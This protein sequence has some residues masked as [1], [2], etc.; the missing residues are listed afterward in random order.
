[1]GMKIFQNQVLKQLI[2]IVD[3]LLK[4]NALPPPKKTKTWKES[5]LP[6]NQPVLR[7]WELTVKPTFDLI[8]PIIST[9]DVCFDRE[10]IQDIV[11]SMNLY[12]GRGKL[13]HKF[14]TDAIELHVVY[15]FL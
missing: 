7:D 2:K 9:I 3:Q 11:N 6:I 10:I 13:G 8:P 12:E 4:I 15:V 1:M 5:R 14:H